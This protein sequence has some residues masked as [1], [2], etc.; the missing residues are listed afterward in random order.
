MDKASF[1]A[2]L[3]VHEIAVLEGSLDEVRGQ[4]IVLIRIA[5]HHYRGGEKWKKLV[6][7]YW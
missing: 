7:R 5:I 3:V 1:V 2:T 6:K 4:V